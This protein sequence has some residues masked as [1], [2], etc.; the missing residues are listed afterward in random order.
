MATIN[1]LR[2][3]R[4][5]FF[6]RVL[7]RSQ[8]IDKI[9]ERLERSVRS[10]NSRKLNVPDLNDLTVCLELARLTAGAVNDMIKELEGGRGIF[11]F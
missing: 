1:E 8:A 7:Q 9:Q 5:A 2:V 3:E 11:N 10:I 6:K 4:R